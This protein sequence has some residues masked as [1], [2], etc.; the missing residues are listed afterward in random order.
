MAIIK[1]FYSN[2]NRWKAYFF[3]VRVDDATVEASV[4]NAFLPTPDGLNDIRDLFRGEECFWTSFT[5]KRVRRAVALHCSRLEPGLPAGE[6]SG[7]SM[8]GFV[9]CKDQKEKEKSEKRK[10]KNIAV[11]NVAAEGQDFPDDV[12]ADYHN[13]GKS[14]E[15]DEFFDFDPPADDGSYE[16]PEFAEASRM[17]NGALLSVSHALSVSRQQARMAQFKAEMADKEIARLKGEP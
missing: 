13:S 10:G 6:E 3:F 14:V 8:D 12:I 5:P 1:E 4:T 15:L 17:I 2:Y 9:P 16:V 7:S 11:D